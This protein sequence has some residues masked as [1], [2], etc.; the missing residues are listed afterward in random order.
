MNELKDEINELTDKLRQ[1]TNEQRNLEE[2]KSNRNVF[3]VLFE[4][5]FWL[6]FSFFQ[7]KSFETIGIDE[8]QTKNGK[9]QFESS[10]RTMCRIRKREKHNDHRNGSVTHRF[11][12]SF[13]SARLRNQHGKD[14]SS[15]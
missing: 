1:T 5:F 7:R 8:C 10:S 3:F 11:Q 14:F 15:F 13:S 2:E 4:R 12:R 6:F 9:S